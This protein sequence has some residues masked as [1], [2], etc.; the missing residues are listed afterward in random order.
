MSR[1]ATTPTVAR[2][3]ILDATVDSLAEHGYAGISVRAVARRAGVSQGALQH[4]FPTRTVLV[5]AALLQLAARLFEQAQ[6]RMLTLPDAQPQRG[7]EVLD[8][9]WEIH[10]LPIA[11]VITELLVAAR[12]DTDL[13]ATI[14]A[15]VDTAHALTIAMVEQA[16][17]DLAAR[18]DFTDWVLTCVATMRGLVVVASLPTAPSSGV[19]WP[20]TRALLLRTISTPA[21]HG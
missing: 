8:M 12:T 14:T 21:D 1:K 9:L 2:D 19:D 15:G 17:P 20:Q 3:A 11:H 4:H 6:K 16:L 13:R 10:N 7:E 5:E 18:P